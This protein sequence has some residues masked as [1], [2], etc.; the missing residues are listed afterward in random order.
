MLSLFDIKKIMNPDRS[1]EPTDNFRVLDSW[2]EY[3]DESDKNPEERDLEYLCYHLEV[4]NPSTGKITRFYKAI[5]FVRVIRLPADAKQS[6]SFMDMQQDVLAAI[7][8]N[9]YNFITVIANIIRPEPIGLLY[10]YG[11]QG[12]STDLQ[13]AK[14]IA[15]QDFI[16]FIATMQGTYRVLEMKCVEAKE[17]EWLREKMYNMD[18]LTM[19]RGIPHANKAGEDAGNKGIGNKNLNPDSEG[20]LEEIIEGMADYEYVIEILSTPVY[21]DTLEGWQRRSQKDMTDWNNH[22]QGTTSLSFN[23]SIP[24][25]Y[26]ANASQSQG[27]SKAYTDA[28]TIST[29]QGESFSTSEGQS[30]GQSLSQSYSQGVSHSSSQSLSNSHSVGVSETVGTTQGTTLGHTYGQT[31][32]STIG[33]STGNSVGSNLSHSTNNSTSLSNGLSNNS[34]IS[35]SLG[36]S[37]NQSSS[38]SLNQSESASLSQGS[39]I[40]QSMGTSQ[41]T[42]Q[43]MS[44]GE[45][46]SSSQSVGQSSNY[47]YN[48]SHSSNQSSSA[49]V[50]QTATQGQSVG[51]SNSYSNGTSWGTSQ[52]ATSGTS[53]SAGGGWS[54]S[55][56][57]SESGSGSI[58]PGGLGL[59]GTDGTSDTTGTSG[60]Y[61][62]GYSSSSSTGWNEGGSATSTQGSSASSSSSLGTSHSLGSSMG[63]SDSYGQSSSYGASESYSVSNGE[64]FSNS[65]GVN[66]SVS[67]SLS[68]GQSVSMSNSLSAGESY[69]TSSSVGDSYSLGQTYSTGESSSVSASAGTGDSYGTSA[70]SNTTS[71][72]S[73]SVSNS[74]SISRSDSYSTSH[75]YGSSESIGQTYGQSTS[76][77]TSETAGS[78]YGETIGRNQ[79]VSNGNS[80]TMSNGTSHSTNSGT[81]G[82]TT[83]GT[84]SSMGLGPSIGYNKAHQW[85]NQGVKDLLELMEFQNERIKKA[86][87]GEGAFYTYIYIACPSLDALSAAQALAKSTWQNEYAMVQPLQVLDLSDSEQSNLLYKFAAFSA[88]ITK[89]DVYGVKEYKYCTVLLPEEFVAYTHLP[90]VSEGGVFSTVLDI[91]KFSVPSMLKGDVYMGTIL[92]PERFTFNNGYKTQ[93]DYR[94]DEQSLMHGFFTGASRS[95]KTVAATRFIAEMAKIRRAK[96]GKRLRIV[97][98]DPKQDWRVLA[99]FV[100]PERFNFYSMGNT[101][102]RP[103]KLNP[104]KVPRGVQPQIWVDGIIDIYCRAYGLLERGKQM[105]ADVVYELYNEAGVFDDCEHDD[106]MDT[107]PRDSARVNFTQIYKRFEQKKI[108]MEDPQNLKGRMGNDTRDAFARLLER[109][110][111]FSRPFSIESKLYG[112]SDG[113]GIDEIIGEDEV[114]VLESK[115]LENTFKNFIF[116]AVTSGFYQYAIAHEGGYLADDQYETVLVIEEANEILIGQDTAGKG[117]QVSLPG[118]SQ[119]EQMLDQAAGYGL[120]I[121]AITQKIADMPSSVIANSGIVFIGRLKREDDI[122]VAVKTIGKD[123]RYDDRDIAK[124]FPRCPTGWFVCQ[125]SRTFDFKDAEPI[126]VQVARLNLNPPNNQELDEILERK[127]LLKMMA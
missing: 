43:S 44:H 66:S 38:H 6:K 21:N 110:S 63:Y 92:N 26:M 60:S 85:M 4:M 74:E 29:A 117:D 50:G 33:S 61:S 67:E 94:I 103:I 79:S 19:V 10:L 24:M 35:Q 121:F 39:N 71:S 9:N 90:R 115:G 80:Y 69:G 81:T 113:L 65:Y 59:S 55:H 68:Q 72:L 37:T 104:W 52:N 56:S 91:P 57:E 127:R 20:T 86:L 109:L 95:G 11:V 83:L 64:S 49:T 31:T 108:E 70:T 5:K 120:F 73:N 106:W 23:L 118:E 114:T 112:T 98:L 51:V 42:S 53:H 100:E 78:S 62:D 89:E 18:Y 3:D 123:A 45:N 17:T 101:N 54:D 126:L 87:R 122:N 99:R 25:M 88:D 125:T 119:F 16:G 36:Q 93:F 34:G 116:G 14:D 1:V 48:T 12:V 82:T 2:A 105:V 47:G 77:S 15:H 7:H 22:L 27:W 124:W 97:V 40:S 41:G 107:V 28:S 13:E 8:E 76:E 102:F 32:G 46:S 111:V 30:I 75:S 96:T 84:S 58:T